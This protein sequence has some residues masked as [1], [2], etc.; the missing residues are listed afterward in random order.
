MKIYIFPILFALLTARTFTTELYFP[1]LTGST[2]ETINPADLGWDISKIDDLYN[3]LEQKNTKAFLLLIDGKIIFEKYFG[4]FTKDSVWYWASAGK[5]LTAT[6]VGIAQEQGQLNIND[7]TSKY[8]GE[9]WTICPKEKEDLITIRHQLTMTTGLDYLIEDLDCTESHCLKY[10]ADAGTQWFYHNAPYTLLE[11]VVVKATGQNYNTYFLQK[12]R[13]YTG[14]S[15]LWAKT[16]YNNVFYSVPRSMARFG[17][18]MLNNGIW[19]NTDIIKDKEYLKSMINTSQDLNKSYGFLWWLNGKESYMIPGL[20]KVFTGKLIPDAPDDMY[21][22]LGKNGQILSIVPSKGLV[23]VRMGDRPD[24]QLFISNQFSN[25]I[26]QYLNQII[27]E[28]TSV[29]DAKNQSMITPNTTSDYIE[30][31]LDNVLPNEPNK[32]I[33]IYNSLG[34]C[35][36]SVSANNYMH[37]QRV[38]ISQLPPGVY[39]VLIGNKATKLVLIR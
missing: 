2:W 24:D 25:Q 30:I 33:S 26:W 34:N 17:L 22:A 18:L 37:L 15:G 14:I 1:P 39:Y 9:G 13:N 6:L 23:V 4:S 19:N 21:S 31:N 12:I 36:M 38:E 3:F 7:K 32:Q 11:Q 35:I 20:T 16:G 5:T 28:G 10:K 27:K 8:L 29:N